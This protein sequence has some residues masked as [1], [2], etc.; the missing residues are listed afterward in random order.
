[1]SEPSEPTGVATNIIDTWKAKQPSVIMLL[2]DTFFPAI[3][4]VVASWGHFETLFED[5]LIALLKGNSRDAGHWHARPFRK[6]RQLFIE[7]ARIAFEG[8]P[9]IVEYFEAIMRDSVA[10]YL[11]RN[12]V[13]HGRL[14]AQISPLKSETK[15]ICVGNYKGQEVKE[16]FNWD[17]LDNL[18]YEIVH[19]SGRLQ[20][21]H[22]DASLPSPDRSKLQAFLASNHPTYPNSQRPPPQP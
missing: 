13:A 10:I 2:P 4:H 18:H 19:L 20:L 12:L 7:E 9:L 1:M 21:A 3:G 6:R 17:E 11:K 22:Q 14:S 8:F 5:F 16:T 15:L